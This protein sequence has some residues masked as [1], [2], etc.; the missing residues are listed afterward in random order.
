[1]LPSTCRELEYVPLGTSEVTPVSLEPSPK[2]TPKEA[3]EVELA[4]TLPEEVMFANN[5][6]LPVIAKLLESTVDATPVN[7]EPSPKYTPKEAV[8]VELPLTLPE[9]VMS[10]TIIS[11]KVL[12]PPP[13]A[14]P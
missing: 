3:V 11:V 14:P 6:L 12:F 4:L 2:Y 1:M 10:V 7:C 13:P 9:A 8:E 5:T